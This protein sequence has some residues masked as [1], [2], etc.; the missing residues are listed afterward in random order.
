[1]Q[2][3][4]RSGLITLAQYRQGG[5][6]SR[7]YLVSRATVPPELPGR[8]FE[9]KMRLMEP[10]A[11]YSSGTGRV[12]M[13]SITVEVSLPEELLERFD[14]RVQAL[15][16]DQA[17]YVREVLERDLR[18]SPPHSQMTFREIVTPSQDGFIAMGPNDVALA[19]VIEAEVKAYRA[20]RRK[21]QSHAT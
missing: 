20:V 1:V 3:Q 2:A 14:A 15:G 12:A 18:E 13:R 4:G 11:L 8:Q 7:A 6:I 21:Q 10:D 16:G 9:A 5:C 17:R 19:E